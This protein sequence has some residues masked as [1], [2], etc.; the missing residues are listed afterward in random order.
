MHAAVYTSSHARRLQPLTFFRKEMMKQHTTYLY[1]EVSLYMR[2]EFTWVLD[3]QWFASVSA[4][5]L[6]TIDAK[7]S[8]LT[9]LHSLDGGFAR[10]VFIGG[11]TV[12]PAHSVAQAVGWRMLAPVT[13]RVTPPVSVVGRVIVKRFKGGQDFKR[14]Y[15]SDRG[16]R[17]MSNLKEFVL[18]A[19]G[20]TLSFTA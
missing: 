6:C 17:T 5:G 14:E 7:Q 20:K 9:T 15:T 19:S 13:A 18:S 12:I 4:P 3:S 10:G 1:E 8:Q 2:D 16:S 11:N